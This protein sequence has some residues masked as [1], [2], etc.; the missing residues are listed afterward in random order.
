MQP[1]GVFVPLCYE[2][3]E[4]IEEIEILALPLESD[5]DD[6]YGYVAFTGSGKI[7]WLD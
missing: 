1:G 2:V 7:P 3:V 4:A 6:L 5:H